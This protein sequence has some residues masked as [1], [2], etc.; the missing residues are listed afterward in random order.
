MNN[1]KIVINTYKNVTRTNDSSLRKRKKFYTLVSRQVN[2]ERDDNL[3][4]LAKGR[5]NMPSCRLLYRGPNLP[6]MDKFC[7]QL[8]K[9]EV[10]AHLNGSIRLEV[11]EE[12]RSY[13]IQNNI[14]QMDRTTWFD[15][16]KIFLR[17]EVPTLSECFKIF[18]MSHSVTI[19]P[20]TV[21][22]ATESVIEDF[23]NDNV[24]YLELRSTLR[25]EKGMTKAKYLESII[26]AVRNC[27][28][29]FPCIIVKLIVSINRKN[30]IQDAKENVDIA[31]RYAKAEPDIVVGIDLSGDPHQKLFTD[32]IEIL[33]KARKH[34]LKLTIHFG[35][36]LGDKEI[37][38][39][40]N[41]E[42]D[43][44]GHGTFVHPDK[45]GSL[46]NWKLLLKKKTPVEICI[47]SNLRCRTVDC[48]EKHHFRLLYSAGHPVILGTD[49]KSIFHTSL[50]SEY[51]IVQSTFNLSKEELWKLNYNAI[52]HAF[53]TECTKKHL[54]DLFTS[55][56]K[57]FMTYL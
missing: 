27:E 11:L 1:W 5:G 10:H 21:Q 29:K 30:S 8:P 35:E 36:I 38:D 12:L 32:F 47:T 31:I 45:G 57:D 51:K 52:D 42:I 26:S 7:E 3:A 33:N 13:N 34:G 14:P 55:W 9:I 49:D 46:Q 6:I 28:Q 39:A 4:R 23:A 19:N 24:V 16:S 41:F 53:C 18:E 44:L 2:N 17:S 15:L 50:S 40:L 54:R 48:P 20:Y 37:N 43:R 56:K 22:R 25:S